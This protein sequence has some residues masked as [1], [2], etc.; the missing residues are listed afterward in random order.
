MFSTADRMPFRLAYL[1]KFKLLNRR[2]NASCT[3]PACTRDRLR[4]Q[5]FSHE[6]DHRIHGLH[7]F[8]ENTIEIKVVASAPTQLLF[9][10]HWGVEL[11]G[12]FGD[13]GASRRKD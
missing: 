12:L 9:T 3:I 11:P 6:R 13:Q 8:R 1:T 7:Q 2:Y 5:M 4:C 10:L